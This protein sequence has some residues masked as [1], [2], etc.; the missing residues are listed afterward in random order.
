MSGP[1]VPVVLR[2]LW[3]GPVLALL[4]LCSTATAA[5][6]DAAGPTNYRSE[7]TSLDPA[8]DG[9]S[10]EVFGGDAFLIL[11]VEQGHEVLV[12]GYEDDPDAAPYL[13]IDADGNVF[14]NRRSP[15]AYLNAARYGSRDVT[16]PPDVDPQAPP[17][18]EQ[19]AS[20]GT[21]AWHDH[22]VHWMSPSLPRQVDP[23]AG[24]TQEVMDW[25]VPIVVDGESVV[26]SGTLEWL[27]SRSA[28]IPWLVV[29]V[30][31]LG[32]GL[33]IHRRPA[34][35]LPVIA[36]SGAVALAHSLADLVVAPP[37]GEAD[38]VRIV[39]PGLALVAV[40]AALAIRGRG[41]R[42]SRLLG[43]LGSVPLLV[44]ASLQLRILT[45]PV[46]VGAVPDGVARFAVAAVL[47]AAGAGLVAG[48]S[49][50]VEP[51]EDAPSA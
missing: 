29:A 14:V 26:V 2:R 16:I 10:A 40:L 20:G 30:V 3:V 24:T 35:V 37:G 41:Q 31:L 13:R 22:R 12:P 33:L 39:L 49:S 19:V 42:G 18:W 21:Y 51:L 50:L 23:E 47:G 27:P 8:V 32:L 46:L 43:V 28:V 1:G 9:V 44:W 36:V 34:V 6:A 38:P 11:R 15:A 48:G 25:Q 4:L 5:V 17:A 7:V 45:A